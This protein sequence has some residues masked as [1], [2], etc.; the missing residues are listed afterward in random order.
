MRRVVLFAIASVFSLGFFASCEKNRDVEFPSPSQEEQ[1]FTVAETVDILT[2]SLT[3]EDLK[4]FGLFLRQGSA[5]ES[6]YLKIQKGDMDYLTGE[7]SLVPGENYKIINLDLS[8]LGMVPIA[9][10]VDAIKLAVYLVEANLCIWNP[11][12]LGKALEKLNGTVN[13]TM[14][15]MYHVE[16]RA[17][18]DDQTGNVSV[19]PFFV[20]SS[21]PTSAIPFDTLFSMI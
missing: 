11:E 6:L 16:F 7:V 21:D 2:K 3:K 18:T 4:D 20:D 13:V 17:V 5:E 19:Q 1:Q 12:L 10:T 14:Y 15:G 8:A 9:G